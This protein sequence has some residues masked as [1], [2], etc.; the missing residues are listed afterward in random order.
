[1][2]QTGHKSRKKYSIVSERGRAVFSYISELLAGTQGSAKLIVICIYIGFLVAGILALYEK[3]ARGAF[4]RA[5]IAKDATS[6][7]KALTLGELGYA[8]KRSI[9]SA[10]RGRGGFAGIVYEAEEE[11]VFDREDHALPVFRE[12]FDPEKARFYIPE[13]VKYRAEVRFEQKGTHIMALVVAAIVFGLMVL[14]AILYM[15]RI[16]NFF[17]KWIEGTREG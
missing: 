1:M 9:R 4:V 15:D 2:S 11:V 5:L 6:P 14:A 7:E 16:V 8:D 10:L 13:P 12:R 17:N 3:R